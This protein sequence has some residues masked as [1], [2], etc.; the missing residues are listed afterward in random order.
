LEASGVL[1]VNAGTRIDGDELLAE[2][3]GALA[4]VEGV[5][6]TVAENDGEGHA[7]TELVGTS[8]RARSEDTGELGEHPVLGGEEA[9]KMTLGTA[10]HF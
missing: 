1:G 7:F 4:V 9:L 6:E 8:A 10:G 3:H 2:D 5:L